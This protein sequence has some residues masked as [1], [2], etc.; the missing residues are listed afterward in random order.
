MSFKND[1]HD[2]LSLFKNRLWKL[3]QSKNLETPRELA[4]E[5]F[6]NS[7]N[8]IDSK[9]G[10]GNSAVLG[11]T[12]IIQKHLNLDGT[13]KLQSRYVLAYCKYFNCSS[14]YLYGL[15]D[16]SSGNRDVIDFCEATGLTEKS[17]K[18]LIEGLPVESK[19]VLIDFWSYV[20]DSQLFY[21]LPYEFRHMCYDLGFVRISDEK[22]KFY[23]SIDAK[24]N[25]S[26]DFTNVLNSM[27][28]EEYQKFTQPHTGSYYMHLYKMTYNFSEFLENWAKDYVPKHQEEIINFLYACLEREH[29]EKKSEFLSSMSDK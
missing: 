11:I 20:L 2:D 6:K 8:I 10:D 4:K 7:P 5:L 29:E 19:E 12:R 17:V 18:R 14:D 25:N 1:N 24:I 3:M 27:M 22:V 28:I 16:I 26:D 9:D 21:I 13:D 15:S 23:N